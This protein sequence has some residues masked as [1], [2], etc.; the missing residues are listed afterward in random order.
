MI[1]G[2]AQTVIG[3]LHDPF[4]IVFIDP[5]YAQPGMR[6]QLFE[7]LDARQLLAENVRIYFEWPAGESFELP[8]DRL[9]FRRQKSAGQVNYAVAEWR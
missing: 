7:S 9:V 2:E 1:R 3:Q 4:D 5:P 6:R 8:S